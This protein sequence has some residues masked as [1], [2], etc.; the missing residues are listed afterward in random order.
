MLKLHKIKKC[1]NDRFRLKKNVIFQVEKTCGIVHML[2]TI[3]A[4]CVKCQH[5]FL[6]LWCKIWINFQV[7]M[8]IAV[9]IC[10]FMMSLYFFIILTPIFLVLYIIKWLSLI[11]IAIIKEKKRKVWDELMMLTWTTWCLYL[12]ENSD[13]EKRRKEVKPLKLVL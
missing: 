6:L 12:D 4:C 10:N 1:N 9:L 13:T 8:I 5:V 7:R 3:I 11:L 2:H